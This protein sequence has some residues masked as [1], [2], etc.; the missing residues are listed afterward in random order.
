MADT[1]SSHDAQQ[2]TR[3]N[4]TC[5][6]S[7]RSSI[8]VTHEWQEFERSCANIRSVLSEYALA[9]AAHKSWL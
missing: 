9:T 3:T 8:H 6:S 4:S 7:T 2:N 5:R 1:S